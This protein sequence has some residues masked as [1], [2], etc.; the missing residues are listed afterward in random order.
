LAEWSDAL[1]RSPAVRE[2]LPPEV[3]ASGWLGYP[4]AT[5]EQLAQAEA[6][7]GVTLPPSYRAFLATSNGWRL[8]GHFIDRLW[9][10]QEIT[11]FRDRNQEWIDNWLEGAR[12]Q[13]GPDPIPDDEY[14]VYGD[15]QRSVSFR[16]EY[17]GASLQISEEGDGAVYLLNPRA[18]T[19]DG[20]WEAWFF[21]NWLPG[22]TRYRSYALTK[23]A[24]ANPP[25]D[26]SE[27]A[28]KLVF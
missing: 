6:R 11:W 3:V 20:E 13:G 28:S 23:N 21:A 24:A 5:G 18:V 4:P 8:T 17:W 25:F 9:S 1:L 16:E 14:F 2:R 10:A 7:L 27:T 19:A 22:A 12:S 15:D 26:R